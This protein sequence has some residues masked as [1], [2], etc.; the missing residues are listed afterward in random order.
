MGV[1]LSIIRNSVFDGEATG[2]TFTNRLVEIEIPTVDI[3]K[4]G[5]NGRAVPLPDMVTFD[6]IAKGLIAMP[7]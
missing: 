6:E 7:H 1:D 3:G 4:S 5:N 2:L